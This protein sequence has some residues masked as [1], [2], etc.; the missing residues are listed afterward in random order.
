MS[1]QFKKHGAP[2]EEIGVERYAPPSHRIVLQREPGL[3]VEEIAL[4]YLTR[5]KSVGWWCENALINGLFGLTF[6]D[7]VFAP[8]PGAFHNP[9]QRGPSDLLLPDF[10]RNR[11]EVITNRLLEIR[12]EHW[13]GRITEA[14][15]EKHGIANAFLNWKRFPEELVQFA[16]ERIPVEHLV[17]LFDR[18]S[19]DVRANSAGFPDLVVFPK[20]GQLGDYSF[21]EV[22]GPGDQL[23]KNQ[24]RWMRH[25]TNLGIYHSVLWV[26]WG[27]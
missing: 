16:V 14:Y 2:F 7:I 20:R 24:L 27:E 13:G 17:P 26:E 12:Q 18:L 25:F 11:D 9:F 10:R 6:W 3:D 4:Q 8:L 15:R 5:D 23:Q 22:K 21:V 1:R 19:R